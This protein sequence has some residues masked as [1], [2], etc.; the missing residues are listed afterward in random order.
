MMEYRFQRLTR[1]EDA[2]AKVLKRNVPWESA[3]KALKNSRM[4]IER[5]F[6]HH[7]T[8]CSVSPHGII[9]VLPRTTMVK[10]KGWPI[11]RNRDFGQAGL[12]N[13]RK[14]DINTS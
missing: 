13:G 5:T 12:K 6:E 2:S 4:G 8:A 14:Y 10:D 9:I 3:E 11:L 1:R 7:I